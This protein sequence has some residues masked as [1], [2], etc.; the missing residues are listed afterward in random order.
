MNLAIRV[1]LAMRIGIGSGSFSKVSLQTRSSFLSRGF[2][3]MVVV[4]RCS[5]GQNDIGLDSED[6]TYVDGASYR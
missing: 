2:R 1:G 3:R 6:D 5:C 4:G